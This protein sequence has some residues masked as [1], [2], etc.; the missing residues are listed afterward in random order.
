MPTSCCVVGCVNRHLKDSIYHFY[1]F[2]MNK[3]QKERWISAVRRVNP[4]GTS[5]SPSAGDR[6]CSV[7]FVGGQK[8]NDPT[9]PAY[10]PTL[11]I[12]GKANPISGETDV[13]LHDSID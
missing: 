11:Y 3:V 4:D 8:N 12:T 9:H 2:P 10:I 6:I 7:H 13:D 1:R 5:W